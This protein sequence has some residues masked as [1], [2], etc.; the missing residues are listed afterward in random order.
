M[1]LFIYI[2]I[3]SIYIEIENCPMCKGICN[4]A[5]IINHTY[6]RYALKNSELCIVC[7]KSK[8]YSVNCSLLEVQTPS[9]SC[10]STMYTGI[11]NYINLHTGI[12]KYHNLH[13]CILNYAKL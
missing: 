5:H 9:Y 6:C 8:L 4:C 10:C 12:I 11:L 7:L 1:Y 13:S 2:C 3:Y